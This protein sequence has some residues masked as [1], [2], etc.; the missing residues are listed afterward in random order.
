MPSESSTSTPADESK[1]T[2]PRTYPMQHG[3]RPAA[4]AQVPATL[5]P[6]PAGIS[7]TCSTG[8]IA[9]ACGDSPSTSGGRARRAGRGAGRE[10]AGG[11]RAAPLL[12][13]PRPQGRLRRHAG[14][15]RPEGGA[16]RPDGHPGLD[17]RPGA[18]PVVLVLLDHRGVGVRAR[19]RGI[20]S[21]PPR[22]RA[23]GPREQHLQGQGGRLCRAAGADESP[24]ALSRLPGLA[25]P[26][27]LS[28]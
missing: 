18:R 28:R 12:R 4:A 26:L 27:L 15:A 10:E 5:V 19:R 8:S 3:H 24:A 20:W 6:R 14:R 25:L 1:L 13:R 11:R 17:A 21:D 7:C 9:T 23:R 22:S 2:E 16:R